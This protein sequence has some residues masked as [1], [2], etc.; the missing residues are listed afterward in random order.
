[1]STVSV[2]S[3]K[4]AK[5]THD[6]MGVD[7][8]RIPSP[9]NDDDGVRVLLRLP[10]LYYGQITIVSIGRSRICELHPFGSGDAKG[11]SSTRSTLIS[12]SPPAL[13]LVCVTLSGS[14]EVCASKERL[15]E[16]TPFWEGL[17]D[18]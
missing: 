11:T 3:K 16:V 5:V 4:C 2:L 13:R 6:V 14:P 15:S 18:L 7:M 17:E 10:I 8:K 12:C 9:G 1:M